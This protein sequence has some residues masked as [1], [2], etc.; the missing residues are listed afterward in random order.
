M[1][2]FMAYCL[3]LS[4]ISCTNNNTLFVSLKKN[5]TQINFQNNLSSTAELNILNYL[6]YYNGA[7]VA[8]ADFNND[9][10]ADL[11][12]TGNQTE[13]KLFLNLGELSLKILHQRLTSITRF[14]GLQ[15]L[16]L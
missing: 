3:L 16:L 7:G 4:L 12:F 13:D 6:Y 11:Y 14:P 2:E 8:A 15:E 10:L 1:R 9:G 5:R